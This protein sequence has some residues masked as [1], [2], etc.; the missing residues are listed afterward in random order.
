MK[1]PIAI[2]CASLVGCSLAIAQ[3]GPSRAMNRSSVPAGE[4]ITN[5]PVAEYISDSAC[6]IGWATRAPGN[7]TL[8]YGTDRA[9]MRQSAMATESADGRNHHVQLSG[10]APNTRYFFQ[11]M[12]NGEP[13]GNVGTFQTVETGEPPVKSK[14]IIPQ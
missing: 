1:K 13:V 3:A 2:V 14:A 4:Q 8:Q 10:L 7:M 12:R 9:K 11:V 6:T 5:G